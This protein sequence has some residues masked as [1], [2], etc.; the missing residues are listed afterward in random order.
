MF[1]AVSVC[2]WV[3]VA[4]SVNRGPDVG[5]LRALPSHVTNQWRSV[6]WCGLSRLKVGIAMSNSV[7][8]V[9]ASM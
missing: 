9:T 6:F 3:L 1:K 8:S 4:L 2:G 5:K 7:P